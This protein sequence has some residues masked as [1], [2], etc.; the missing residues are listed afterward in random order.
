MGD[1]GRHGVDRTVLILDP[2]ELNRR[3][4]RFCTASRALAIVLSTGFLS[5]P[6]SMSGRQSAS[7][8]VQSYG[9][10]SPRAAVEYTVQFVYTTTFTIEG[11][12]RKRS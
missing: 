12:I 6:D 11:T 2:V 4:S 10:V 3:C 1:I 8:L 7:L 5:V 9:A